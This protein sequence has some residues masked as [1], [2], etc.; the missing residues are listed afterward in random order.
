MCGI[1]GFVRLPEPPER[2]PQRITAMLA[3]LAHRGPDEVGYYVDD[4]AAL[5]ASRLS[6]IDLATG[7]QPISS[8]D[9]RHWICSNGELYNYVELRRELQALGRRFETRSDT[10]VILQA[11]LEWGEASL[12]RLN[13]AFAFAVYDSADSSLV[14]ARDRFGKRPLFY[15]VNDR[16]FVFASEMKAFLPLRSI[17]FEFEA[18]RLATLFTTWS[19]L[20]HETAFRG[21]DQLAPGELLRVDEQGVRRTPYFVLDFAQDPAPPDADAAAEQIRATLERSVAL[22]LRSD[23]EVGVYVSGGV[24]SA[25]VAAL[26]ARELGAPP[27]TFSIEFEDESVD[28]SHEQG[29]VAE[30]LGST[31]AALRVSGRDIAEHFPEAVFHAESPAFRTAFVPMFLLSRLVRDSGVKVVLTG[32]GSDEA[33]LG[34]GIFKDTLLLSSWNDLSAD[35]K[36]E[37]LARVHPYLDHFSE[38][39]GRLLGLYQQLASFST[40]GIFSHEM[41]FQ[42]GRF[43]ARLLRDAGDP[44]PRVLEWLAGEP[45]YNA[46]SPVQKAQ[47]LE[48]KT[49]LAGYLLSTQ[50]DRMA[51]AHGVENRCPFLD[52]AV[53]RLAAS[54]NLRFDDGYDEKWL[55]KR[56]MAGHAPAAV[57]AKGKVPYR[58]PDS[59]AF[60]THRPEYIDELLDPRAIEDLGFLDASF[61][62]ALTKRILTRAPAQI[63]TRENQTWIFLLSL[64]VLHR[65]FIKRAGVGQRPPGAVP[66]KVVDRRT[67]LV[68]G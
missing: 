45:S 62:G 16:A 37:R 59:A 26:A 24:D 39:S 48:F 57:I 21:I 56:A 9:E 66:A 20:P 40:S 34:Y 3:Q 68:A 14:L 27:R 50:G 7:I 53:V 65:Q 10:E 28:E 51:M 32:E 63:S 38:D 41:R 12:P 15:T 22:R 6:I 67:A 46:L 54:V 17:D 64:L 60:T 13:G 36:R 44:I 25:I 5:G 19:T 1:A 58:A 43:S 47:W 11:W 23:V 33:F 30:H 29:L 35:E 18:S 42:N 8:P 49:L 31:H 4:R 61:V 2:H 55:L 52:P